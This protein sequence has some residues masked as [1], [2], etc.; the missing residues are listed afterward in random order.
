MIGWM[1]MNGDSLNCHVAR[2][3]HFPA[4][5]LVVPTLWFGLCNVT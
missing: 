5:S 4:F 3:W 2:G 1:G